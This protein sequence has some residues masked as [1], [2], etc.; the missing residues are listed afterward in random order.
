ML[1][2]VREAKMLQE[3]NLTERITHKISDSNWW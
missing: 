1:E 3:S 2:C